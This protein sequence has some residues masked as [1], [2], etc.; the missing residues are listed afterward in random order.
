MHASTGY[1]K[2]Y[3]NR[4]KLPHV[5]LSIR[6]RGLGLV[7]RELADRLADVGPNFVQ[8]QVSALLRA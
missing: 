4:L 1:A 8:K 3:V 6:Q 7:G 2:F 5:Q